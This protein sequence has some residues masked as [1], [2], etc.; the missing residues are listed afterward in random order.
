MN[1]NPEENRLQTLFGELRQQ[2]ERLCPSFERTLS[3]ALARSRESRPIAGRIGY[4]GYL[5]AAAALVIVGVTV[6]MLSHH[7]ARQ[8]A[9]VGQ[10]SRPDGSNTGPV[11]EPPAMS[12]SNWQSPT[13]F[14]LQSP[15]DWGAPSPN[16]AGSPATQPQSQDPT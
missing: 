14:L 16:D 2:D 11:I 1:P 3:A 5:S 10:L 6:G 12:L 15:D 9:I 13:A 7:P 4:T 8:P